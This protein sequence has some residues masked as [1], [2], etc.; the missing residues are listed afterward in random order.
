MGEAC[1]RGLDH[2]SLFVW[3]CGMCEADE[4]TVWLNRLA[5]GDSQAACVIWENY[6]TKLVGLARRKMQDM[7]RRAFDE[8][9]AALSAMASFCRGVE[10]GKFEKLDDRTDLWKLLVTITS[11]KIS[12]QQAR[13]RRVKRGGGHVRGESAFGNRQ[14]DAESERAGGIANALGREPTP[15]LAVSVVET[16]RR[17]LDSLGDDTARR[18]AVMKLEGYNNREISEQLGC[19]RRT[20]ERKLERVRERWS[21]IEEPDDKQ[22]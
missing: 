11:R 13:S 20:V 18:I 16:T 2:P 14:G 5:D 21:A 15:E 8:E 1:G 17:L 22:S 6:F 9:D 3:V 12:A 19:A 10:L 7:S 4:I